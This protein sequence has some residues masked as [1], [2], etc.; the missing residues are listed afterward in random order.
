MINS[1][2]LLATFIFS[3]HQ[4]GFCGQHIKA[5]LKKAQSALLEK[6][7]L[8]ENYFPHQEIKKTH[9]D[10][11]KRIEKNGIIPYIYQNHLEKIQES[12]E[13]ISGIP[14]LEAIENE[15]FLQ[16]AMNCAVSPYR[17]LELNGKMIKGKHLFRKT[18]DPKKLIIM[19][20]LKDML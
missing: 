11:N 4:S 9:T 10:L 5:P 13:T 20:G 6:F 1:E 7:I 3:A 14:F 16:K 8:N 19:P 17:V 15:I 12:I 2:K 18:Q